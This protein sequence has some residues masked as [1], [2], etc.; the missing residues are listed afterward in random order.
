MWDERGSEHAQ[1][2]RALPDFQALIES[3]MS[4]LS[5]RQLLTM[6]AT[7]TASAA[8]SACTSV[9]GRGDSAYVQAGVLQPVQ[10]P[11]FGADPLSFGDSHLVYAATSDDGHDVPAVP[12][13]KIDP[14][15]YRQVVP[16]PTGEPPGTIVIDTATHFLYLALN[17][18]KAI[19][20]GVGLGRQG[21]E[22][23]G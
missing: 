17:G 12:I 2:F 6:A 7:S 14:R 8:L 9:R 5:R 15:Y 1:A 18:G 3:S 4:K 10:F 21:F 22:W 23:S 13:D 16:D 19:R 20:Y 11:Q